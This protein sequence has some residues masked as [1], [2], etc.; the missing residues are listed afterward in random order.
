MSARP[1]SRL[2]VI[3]YAPLSVAGFLIG[4]GPTEAAERLL[5]INGHP[6]PRPHGVTYGGL[7]PRHGYERDHCL[8]LGLGGRDVPSNV[9]YQRLPEAHRKDHIEDYY[10]EAYCRGDITLAEARAHLPA[11]RCVPGGW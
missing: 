11:D 1:A 6:A 5:C 2:I 8:P 4:A 3:A 9:W 7:P 10:I